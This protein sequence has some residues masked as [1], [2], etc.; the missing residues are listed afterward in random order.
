MVNLV[1]LKKIEMQMAIHKVERFHLDKSVELLTESYIKNVARIEACTMFC[2]ISSSEAWTWNPAERICSC[3]RVPE[4]YHCTS[5]FVQPVYDTDTDLMTNITIFIK[6]GQL[7]LWE[8]CS[9]VN[10]AMF[11]KKPVFKVT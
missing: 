8:D 10:G 5:Y 6:T 7:A 3:V 11:T 1:D 9:G 2:L 4:S